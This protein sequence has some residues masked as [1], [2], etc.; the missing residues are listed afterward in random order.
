M[1]K[2][3]WIVH[4]DVSN[5]DG[6]KDYVA[7]NAMPLKKYGAKFLVR[8]GKSENPGRKKGGRTENTRDKKQSGR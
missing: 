8:G 5:P 2:G 7:A 1:P 4:I 3:Y 6:Y